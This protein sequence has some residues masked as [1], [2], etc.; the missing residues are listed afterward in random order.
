MVRIR[1]SLLLVVAGCLASWGSFLLSGAR[2]RTGD[3]RLGGVDGLVAIGAVTNTVVNLAMIQ[4]M[5]RKFT[6]VVVGTTKVAT[7][8]FFKGAE[9]TAGRDRG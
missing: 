3:E 1:P 4:G 6:G 9:V 2:P 8:R 7:G 5:D